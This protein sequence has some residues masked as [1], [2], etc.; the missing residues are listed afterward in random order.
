MFVMAPG[1]VLICLEQSDCKQI[2]FFSKNLKISAIL[3]WYPMRSLRLS[4][5]SV[6]LKGWLPSNHLYKMKDSFIIY[7]YALVLEIVLAVHVVALPSKICTLYIASVTPFGRVI[8]DK[9]LAQISQWMK[10]WERE[11]DEKEVTAECLKSSTKSQGASSISSCDSDQL[12]ESA[13]VSSTCASHPCYRW[14]DFVP[15]L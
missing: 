15:W 3:Q 1:F 14:S 8:G 2:N 6:I 11:R 12:L 13:F 9:C 10:C 5:R 4:F 7:R